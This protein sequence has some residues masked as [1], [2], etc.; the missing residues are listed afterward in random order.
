MWNANVNAI[1]ERAGVSWIGP[2]AAMSQVLTMGS[3]R[4]QPV[5][6]RE[7]VPAV[8]APIRSSR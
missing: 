5:A 8:V 6:G 7:P 1:C 4:P 3:L 2:D